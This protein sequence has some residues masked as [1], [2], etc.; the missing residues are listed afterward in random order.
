MIPA[1]LR[2]TKA[3]V[4][5]FASMERF[6]GWNSGR[7]DGLVDIKVGLLLVV[8]PPAELISGVMVRRS[9]VT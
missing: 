7:F 6:I 1:T 9:L 3:T 2:G 4:M 8:G 5:G